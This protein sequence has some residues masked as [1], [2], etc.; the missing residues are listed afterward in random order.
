MQQKNEN[1]NK[2]IIEEAILNA[3]VFKNFQE[4]SSKYRIRPDISGDIMDEILSFLH[5][6]ISADDFASYIK[7]L[8]G[9]TEE[10]K[11]SFVK[12]VSEKITYLVLK[13]KEQ[14][15]EDMRMEKIVEQEYE[16]S[17]NLASDNEDFWKPEYTEE[18]IDRE[19]EEEL[20]KEME[21]ESKREARQEVEQE[22]KKQKTVSFEHDIDLD[23]IPKTQTAT[24]GIDKQKAGEPIGSET[25]QKEVQK[26]TE[27]V[28][29][30]KT[31]N[32]TEEA[33]KT[34]SLDFIQSH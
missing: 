19:I 25:L 2:D 26:E 22:Y 20:R 23:N 33:F 29:Q 21:F 8:E 28:V 30:N 11:V 7:N 12:D 34:N 9:L 32:K 24:Y 1:T 31:P 10:E 15:L 14:L 17:K 27:H 18:E 13:E 6:E 3:D 4:I 5:N 16:K